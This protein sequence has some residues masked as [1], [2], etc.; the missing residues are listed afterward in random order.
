M[1]ERVRVHGYGYGY[2]DP[3]PYPYPAGT[4]RVWISPYPPGTGRVRILPYPHSST[5]YMVP[6][7]SSYIELTFSSK[8]QWVPCR[9]LQISQFGGDGKKN[10]SALM[11]RPRPLQTLDQ[12]S[13]AA[14]SCDE[15]AT[16]NICG[17]RTSLTHIRFSSLVMLYYPLFSIGSV[18]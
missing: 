1:T 10:F 16:L 2:K 7:T 5:K 14:Y 8:R 3:Y 12:V 4:G 13:A 6:Y 17:V 18:Q 9:P 15:N 11:R